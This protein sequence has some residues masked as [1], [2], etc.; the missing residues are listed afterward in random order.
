MP[1]IALVL[2]QWH[3][4]IVDQ[5]QEPFL[6]RLGQHRFLDVDVFKV[7]GA[8]EIPLHVRR[9][10]RRGGYDAAAAAALV[11]D[12]GIY[13]HDFVASTVVEALMRVQL[14]ED[15]PV[16]SA[17]LT[18]HQFHAHADHRDF[19]KD[20]FKKKGD[21]LADAVAGTLTSLASIG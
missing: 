16:F 8:F 11:T 3:E 10:I 17:V 21:E 15:T 4:E 14:E 19:F 5:L 9:L 2:A 7:P 6:E 1:K 20:H 12:G 18:P 13:R